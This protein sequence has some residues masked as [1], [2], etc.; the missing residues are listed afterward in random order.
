M[1]STLDETLTSNKIQKCEEE[2]KW[3]KKDNLLIEVEKVMGT[4]ELKEE[5]LKKLEACRQCGRS[6]TDVL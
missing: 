3:P 1:S 2:D 6:V 5:A 4:G